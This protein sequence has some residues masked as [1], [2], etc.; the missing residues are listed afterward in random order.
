VVMLGYRSTRPNAQGI[1]S[2]WNAEQRLHGARL[3]RDWLRWLLDVAATTPDEELARHCFRQVAPLVIEP[4]A[5]FDLPTVEE[6]ENWVEAHASVRPMARQWLA[7]AW[8]SPLDDWRSGEH[9]RQLKYKARQIE[10]RDERKRSL[11][12]YLA[13]LADGTAPSGLLHR[14][15]LA[16]E[17]RFTDIRGDS[18]LERLQ[19]FLVADAA[20]A[21][22]ALAAVD[23]VL[24]RDDLPSANE[25]LE[26][27]AK[28][29]YHLLRPAALLA[30][31]RSFA[32][33]PEAPL[34]WPL[35]LAKTLVAFYLT[36]GT[37]EMPAWYRALVV[38]RPTL[39]APILV[40]YAVPKLKH[41][42][43]TPISGLWPLSREADHQALARLV[44]PDLLQAFPKRAS[45][46]SRGELNRSLLAALPLLDDVQ[47]ARIVH[48]K[49]SL[50]GLDAAQRICWLVAELP[51]RA[52]AAEGLAKWVGKNER[53]AVALGAAL[54]E[55][56][57]LGRTVRPLAP[58]AVRHLIEVLAPI[59]PREFG[60]E[61]GVVS[62]ADNREQ[63]TRGL[64]EALSSNPSVAAHDELKALIHSTRL[65]NWKDAIERSVRVQQSIARESLFVAAAPRAVALAIA[66]LTPASRADLLALVVQH[67]SDIEAEL[68]G[69]NSY[70]L[71]QFWKGRVPQDENFC[72]DLLLSKLQERLKR[73]DVHIEREAS[74]AA[75]KRADMRAEFMQS[76]QRIAVPI[77]VKKENHDKLWTAWRDQ[78]QNLYLIDPAAGGYG[79]YLVLWFEHRPR[80]TPE[81]LKP[82]SAKHLQ[83]LLTDRIPQAERY[84]LAV[85]V[86]DLAL[87]AS[88]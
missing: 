83:E 73:L 64:L 45:E 20:T 63:T 14:I 41:K 50:V 84:R 48:A 9:Q 60:S 46:A 61:D 40:R 35:E 85:Q 33:A 4:L 57:S 74:A 30:A 69:A 19:D 81:G 78:L 54:Y 17:K 43:N 34:G 56:G 86:L 47:A 12:P 62:M 66:N 27:D 72:R 70:L 21:E 88:P 75:D 80:A 24:S 22:N 42:G 79:L 38:N 1:R 16:H 58:T 65:G 28:G 59:T 13:A 23:Q 8:T 39:V 82:L 10:T 15:A 44:L 32:T 36:D 6:L 76:G 52:E 11:A 7:E 49:L 5:R 31:S 87:P 2:F 77:E 25:V 68:R 3:P 29:E 53:R 67:L 51:F 18:P 26:A 71:R 37:G 55:Q